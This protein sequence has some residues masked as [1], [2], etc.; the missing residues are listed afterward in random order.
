[1]E[2]NANILGSGLEQYIEGFNRSLLEGPDGVQNSITL[3]GLSFREAYLKGAL[4]IAV[5]YS[6]RSWAKSEKF[7]ALAMISLKGDTPDRNFRLSGDENIQPLV[8]CQPRNRWDQDDVFVGDVQNVETVKTEFPSFVWLYLVEDCC[9]DLV[10]WRNSLLFMSVDGTFKRLPFLSKG[11][12][13]AVARSSV[14]GFSK[15]VVRVVEGGMEV[16]QG[17]AENGWPMLGEDTQLSSPMP[18]QRARLLLG[19][20]T[21]HVVTDVLPEHGFELTDVLFGPFNL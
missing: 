13:N 6:L 20:Q 10:A 19:P 21:F 11:E 18:F 1:M 7:S 3:K 16:V 12:L 9:D 14:I 8:Y 4:W 15:D 17:I 5:K 2:R